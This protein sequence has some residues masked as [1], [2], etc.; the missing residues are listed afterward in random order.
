MWYTQALP[1]YNVH[2][3]FGARGLLEIV[4]VV[5]APNRTENGIIAFVDEEETALSLAVR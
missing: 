5:P 1:V 4:V 2:P 3:G